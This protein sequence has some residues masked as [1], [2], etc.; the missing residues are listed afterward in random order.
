MFAGRMARR[1]FTPSKASEDSGG[2]AR[3]SQDQALGGK[4]PDQPPAARAQRLA[5]SE[6]LHA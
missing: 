1:P 6:F 5:D 3:G 4:L 2:A